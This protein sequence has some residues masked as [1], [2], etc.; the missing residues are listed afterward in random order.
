MT[1]PRIP[2][3]RDDIDLV[4]AGLSLEEGFLVSRVDG[5]TSVAH[6]AALVGKPIDE[7]ERVVDRLAAV[8]VL[9]LGEAASVSVDADP[10]HGFVFDPEALSE[11]VDLE[12]EE[13]K[14]ILYTHAQLAT[15]N[16]YQRLGVRWRDDVRAVKRAYFER[17][18]EWHPDRFRRP[19]LGR[20]KPLIDDIFRSIREAYG[21]LSDPEQKVEYDR[22]YAP[23]F[24]EEDMAA[25][26]TARRTEERAE[27]REEESRRRRLEKNPLRQRMQ[28]ARDL[29]DRALELEKKGELIE[30]LHHAQGAV[31][32][33]G[34]EEF[35]ELMRRL[36]IATSE[37][38]VAPLLRRG[39][40]AES[41]TS[42]DDAVDVFT[43]A[44][45]VAPEHG[46]ARLRL[47]YNL[48][49]GGRPPNQAHEHIHKALL[50]L[51]E[52]AE[53]HFVRGLCY[54]KAGSDKAAVRAYQKALELRPNYMEAKKRLKRL[55]WG[56]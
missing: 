54:E 5:R 11:D 14:R 47:A 20:Y 31:A 42:W 46:Q 56:F 39:Q 16:H 24:D 36:Q 25:M 45:R 22:I 52:E 18:K 10:Y 8:G 1:A 17:S 15:W 53:A 35:R 19:R 37:A 32:F 7:T 23:T 9:V 2:R 4:R 49:M 55:R 12:P 38:R 3:V 26:L 43:E 30:A 50:L 21:V 28:R 13:K 34:R 40:A 33:H 48:L 51:P 44:V 41:M 6:L 29:Y 27:A